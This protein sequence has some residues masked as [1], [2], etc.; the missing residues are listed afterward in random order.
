MRVV[1][2]GGTGFIGHALVRALLARGDS[3]VVFT[4][5]ERHGTS[6]FRDLPG[7][8]SQLEVVTWEPTR[9][10]RWQSHLDG[11]DAVVHLA[12]EV[13]VGRRQTAA[14]MREAHASRVRSAELLVDGMRKASRAP[15]VFVSGSAIGYYGDRGSTLLD[16]SAPP[17]SDTLA[18]LCVDWER[19]AHRA[20]ELGVRVVCSRTG[21][22]LGPNG[23]ALERMALPFRMFVG[24]P[25]ASGKQ[26]V[27]WIHLEDLAQALLFCVDQEGIVGG[28]NATAPE[29]VTNE[30]L[31]RAI[32]DALGRPSWLR[33]PSFALRAAFGE[34]AAPIVGG[35]RVAPK[36]LLDHGFS[37]R[38]ARVDDAVRA[39]LGAER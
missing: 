25:I 3:P 15:R 18:E 35:Q 9:E 27:S 34:G 4:R 29:P 33:V 32:A 19:A 39:A 22:A 16:E 20:N 2:T 26:Y 10:G 8:A 11:A 1:V 38:F 28:V 17:G 36:K 5:D 13:L 37:F 14:V 23:G 12:G 7:S 31:S 21:I 24:G 6:A 30:A